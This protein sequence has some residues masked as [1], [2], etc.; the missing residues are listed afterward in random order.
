MPS[1]TVVTSPRGVYASSAT[2]WNRGTPGSP[3]DSWIGLA[4]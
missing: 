2:N 4:T 3:R 1:A